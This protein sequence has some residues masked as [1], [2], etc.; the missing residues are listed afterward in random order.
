MNKPYITNPD[1]QPDY[2]FTTEERN[3]IGVVYSEADLARIRAAIHELDQ[4]EIISRFANIPFTAET[5][6]SDD[7]ILPTN[8]KQTKQ[9]TTSIPNTDVVASTSATALP[10]TSQPTP[11]IQTLSNTPTKRNNVHEDD[12]IMTPTEQRYWN[13]RAD[14]R[15][16]LATLPIP[17]NTKEWNDILNYPFFQIDY[18]DY[19]TLTEPFLPLPDNIPLTDPRDM[20]FFQQ[21]CL[22][23]VTK[24]IEPRAATAAAAAAAQPPADVQ[25]LTEPPKEKQKKTKRF[26]VKGLRQ[27][28]P[29]NEK[30]K[31]PSDPSTPLTSADQLQPSSSDSPIVTMVK[32]PPE[33]KRRDVLTL[34]D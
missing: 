16:Y 6:Y 34:P 4:P 8:R 11:G 25:T 7:D 27:Q 2:P 15:R 14:R 1:A 3:T 31:S 18:D 17:E 28:T 26:T 22:D 29:P 12:F 20:A 13:C 30:S 9:P 21:Y 10:S 33:V 24:V 23:Y 5:D 32:R 19:P